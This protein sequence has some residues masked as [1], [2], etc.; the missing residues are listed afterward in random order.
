MPYN[1]HMANQTIT[2]PLGISRDLKIFVHGIPYTFAFIVI[3]NNVLDY[4]YSMLLG[5]LW[6]RHAKYP[7]IGELILLPYKEHVQYEPYMLL[8]NLVCKPKNQKS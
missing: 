2:K 4:S 7:M 3:N 1:L 8:R 6:L 5:C